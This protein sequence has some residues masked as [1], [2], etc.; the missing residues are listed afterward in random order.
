MWVLD[1]PGCVAALP[2]SIGTPPKV[3]GTPQASTARKRINK[4]G[5]RGFYLDCRMGAG[6]FSCTMSSLATATAHPLLGGKSLV[7]NRSYLPIHVT[8]VRRA[9]SL[10]Y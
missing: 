9:F 7:L 6:S 8:T 5:N 1:P 3:R 4:P 10:L 2:R